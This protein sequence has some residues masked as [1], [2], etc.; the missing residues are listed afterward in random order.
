MFLAVSAPRRFFIISVHLF[1]SLDLACFLIFLLFSFYVVCFG[2]FPPQLLALIMNL[3]LKATVV[4]VTGHFQ[5]L[6]AVI[7]LFAIHL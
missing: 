4:N 7:I 2:Y 5:C 3:T 6:G 1:M